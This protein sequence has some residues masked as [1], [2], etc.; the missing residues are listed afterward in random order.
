MTHTGAAVCIAMAVIHRATCSILPDL[1]RVLE[2]T[3][4]LM[5]T[6]D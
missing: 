3:L 6:I 1:Q 2:M 5:V 4:V